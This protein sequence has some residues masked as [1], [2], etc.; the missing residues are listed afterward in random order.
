MFAPT[1]RQPHIF[2]SLS[3]TLRTTYGEQRENKKQGYVNAGQK[4]TRFSGDYWSLQPYCETD[5]TIDS[6]PRCPWRVKRVLR[7]GNTRLL[8]SV[9]LNH[10]LTAEMGA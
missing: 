10:S 6:T 7:L 4:F 1:P 9:L 5:R 8:P 3:E 2:P